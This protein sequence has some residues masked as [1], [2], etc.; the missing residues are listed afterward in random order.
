MADLRLMHLKDLNA[1]NALLSKAF[2]Q[3]R[4]DDGY[5]VT[6]VPMC[7]PEFLEMYY[8]ANPEGSFVIEEKN[9]IFACAFSH[10]WGQVGWIGPIAVMPRHQLFGYGKQITH[11]CIKFLQ[12]KNCK[13]I[14]LETMPRSYRNLGLYFKLGFIAQEPTVEIMRRIRPR[15]G[16]KLER[17]HKMVFYSASPENIKSEFLERAKK[18]VQRIDPSLDYSSLIRSVYE[19]SYGDSILMV[20][21]SATI[22][23]AVVYWE[24]IFTDEKHGLLKIVA[25]TAHPRMPDSYFHFL[26]EDFEIIALA[27]GLDHL[28]FRV[29]TRCLR[30]L[31][32][33]LDDK[34]RIVHSDLRMTL[35]GYPKVN[36]SK[37]LHMDRWE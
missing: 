7:R 17:P 9:R 6:H 30:A 35:Q 33:L 18:L 27:Q 26:I 12:E 16:S 36:Y 20:R 23:V 4:E 2:T 29:P 11:E 19:Y 3:G 22:A 1:V 21:N 31:K 32:L 25:L 28:L 37:Y 14:G 13:T 10:I 5:R 15:I 8:K 24:P 34:F